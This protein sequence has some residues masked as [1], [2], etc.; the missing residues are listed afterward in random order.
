MAPFIADAASK[1]GAMNDAY[2]MP[3][4]RPTKW[5]SPSPSEKR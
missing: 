5:P 2:E 3:S 4:T 1:P